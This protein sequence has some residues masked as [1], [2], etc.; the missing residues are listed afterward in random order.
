MSPCSGG[1]VSLPIESL[2]FS[3]LDPTRRC[4]RSFSDIRLFSALAPVARCVAHRM[5][6][7]GCETSVVSSSGAMSRPRVR[8]FGGGAGIAAVRPQ[9]GRPRDALHANLPCAMQW[10]DGGNQSRQDPERRARSWRAAL[11]DGRGEGGREAGVTRASERRCYSM[12]QG[13]GCGTRRRR[14]AREATQAA[15]DR[16]RG[17]GIGRNGERARICVFLMLSTMLT[18]H[19]WQQRIRPARR[20]LQRVP[21]QRTSSGGNGKR[22][23]SVASTVRCVVCCVSLGA[24]QLHGGN[25][26]AGAKGSGR[27]CGRGCRRARG[28]IQLQ[29]L[30]LAGCVSGTDA[31]LDA[32]R[33]SSNGTARRSPLAKG[34]TPS[35]I[36]VHCDRRAQTCPPQGRAPASST[37]RPAAPPCS[38]R[39]AACS[40]CRAACSR[41]CLLRPCAE[42]ASVAAVR[43]VTASNLPSYC[44]GYCCR[45]C[46]RTGKSGPW[47]CEGVCVC[48]WH[49]RRHARA[50]VLLRQ[51]AGHCETAKRR[52]IVA[53]ANCQ[54][55]RTVVDG[56]LPVPIARRWGALPLRRAVQGASVAATCSRHQRGRVVSLWRM[57]WGC[58]AAGFRSR[59]RRDETIGSLRSA[60][61]QGLGRTGDLDPHDHLSCRPSP[62][63]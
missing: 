4:R 36:P 37:R 25:G 54:R 8:R 38:R 22:E 1:P 19:G 28:Y 49:P 60:S 39:C 57:S 13:E 50:G 33:V 9:P 40:R 62:L 56:G 61:R 41:R 46:T 21:L 24:E 31:A 30:P 3:P 59:S 12:G 5:R 48:I 42:T 7:V 6:F 51:D 20:R 45:R 23:I 15:A 17:D 55:V 58:S 29:S 63:T 27:G 35:S 34:P 32:R 11:A 53:V 47:R 10:R 44:A 43:C 26:A 18:E 52:N 14:C 2:F 16:S